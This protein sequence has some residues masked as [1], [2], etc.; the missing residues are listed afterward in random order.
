MHLF[1]EQWAPI[2]NFV[3]GVAHVASARAMSSPSCANSRFPIR[4]EAGGHLIPY[5]CSSHVDETL[6]L[7]IVKAAAADAPDAFML[8]KARTRS[9]DPP[10]LLSVP[11][12]VT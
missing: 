5:G 9:R 3:S 6:F 4:F 1:K 2:H 7:E 11:E 12:P 8:M 10:T